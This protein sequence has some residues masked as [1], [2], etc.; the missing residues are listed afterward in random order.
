MP[1]WAP[2]QVPTGGNDN[3]DGSDGGGP[4]DGDDDDEKKGLKHCES[5]KRRSKT[6][7]TWPN[8]VKDGWFLAI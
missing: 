2:A 5:R 6:V 3:D 7:K 1:R 8:A 4:D